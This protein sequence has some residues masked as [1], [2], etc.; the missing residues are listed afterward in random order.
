M[1]PMTGRKAGLCAGYSVPGYQNAAG[2]GGGFGRGMGRGRGICRSFAAMSC[3]AFPRRGGAWAADDE[4]SFLQSRADVL[5]QQLQQVKQR[6][7]DME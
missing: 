2:F 3:G 1:G 5:E 6:L 7:N 4:K